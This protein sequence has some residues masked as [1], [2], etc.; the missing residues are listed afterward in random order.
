[1]KKVIIALLLLAWNLSSN[2]FKMFHDHHVDQWPMV[3]FGAGGYFL[4][5]AVLI[6][7]SWL[8]YPFT[9]PRRWLDEAVG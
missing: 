9:V 4:A 3:A 5:S 7:L 1:M 8:G 2:I 6:P